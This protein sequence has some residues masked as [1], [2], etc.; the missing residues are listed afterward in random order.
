M[1]GFLRASD[2]NVPLEHSIRLDLVFNYHKCR[3]NILVVIYDSSR[4]ALH[5][6]MYTLYLKKISVKDLL[7]FQALLVLDAFLL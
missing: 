1:G 6:M 3:K 2:Q 4:R 5:K 7:L